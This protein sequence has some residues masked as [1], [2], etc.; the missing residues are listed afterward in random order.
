MFGYTTPAHDRFLLQ[1]SVVLQPYIYTLTYICNGRLEYL[2]SNA[3][4]TKA[5]PKL[6]DN[7][8]LSTLLDVVGK[9]NVSSVPLSF[10]TCDN[11]I[12]LVEFV[13]GC[14]NC[15]FAC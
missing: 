9:K 7:S 13:I 10:S 14:S 6:D 12:M 15:L 5:M 4:G 8:K 2:C 1:R 3:S 11:L